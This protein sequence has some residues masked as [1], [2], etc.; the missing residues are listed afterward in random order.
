MSPDQQLTG[1]EN[2]DLTP[3]LPPRNYVNVDVDTTPPSGSDEKIAGT[4]EE[5]Q[6][7]QSS[8]CVL[9]L[10]AQTGNTSV[11]CLLLAR[12]RLVVYY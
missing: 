4:G 1:D 2:S 9:L 12:V 3:P 10:E 7:R 5:P 8:S 11:S 6:E